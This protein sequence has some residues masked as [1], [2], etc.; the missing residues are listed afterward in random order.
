LI[1]GHTDYRRRDRDHVP[2]QRVLRARPGSM[3]SSSARPVAETPARTL[4]ETT[5][6]LRIVMV[7][8][9]NGW[10]APWHEG[11]FWLG[12][13]TASARVIAAGGG[14]VVPGVVSIGSS[15]GAATRD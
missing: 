15:P 11:F 4:P 6:A 2:L 13:E 10:R 3:A 9:P 1:I 8:N 12:N 5:S 7:D 14:C